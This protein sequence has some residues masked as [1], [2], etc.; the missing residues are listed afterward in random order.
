M[1]MTTVR[2]TCGGAMTILA[3]LILLLTITGPTQAERS[4]PPDAVD[5]VVGAPPEA[6]AEQSI[7]IPY[8]KLR[9]VFEREGRGVFI[10]YEQF[11]TLWEA[12]RRATPDPQNDATPADALI[13]TTQN[14][15]EVVGDAV[16]VS[17]MIHIEVFKKGWVRVPLRLRDAAIIRATIA[18]QPARVVFDPAHGH[19]LIY[20]HQED[21]PAD[22]QLRLEY[23]KAVNK[24][25]GRHGVA[26]GPPQA[27]VSRWRITV[28]E[29]D[30]KVE[31]EPMIATTQTA[32]D[33]HTIKP[34]G[35]GD[36]GRT[37]V[38]AFVGAAPLVRIHW[39]PKSEG[40]VG[41]AALAELR[42]RQRVWVEE[43]VA[44]VRADLH[45]QISRAELTSLTLDLPSDYKITDV[46][47]ANARR[48][49]V[50]TNGDGQRLTV[51]LFEPAD[52]SQALT[53]LLERLIGDSPRQ[54]LVTPVIKAHGVARQRGV[55]AVHSGAGLVCEVASSRGVLQVGVDELTADWRAGGW[56]F[57]YRYAALP[58]SL[59][60]SVEK[61]EPVVRARV[62]SEA[63]IQPRS[64]RL[65]SNVVFDV[66]RTG[67]FQFEL[68]VPSGFD[69]ESVR[70]VALAGSAAATVETHH[71]DEA[72][73]RLT[74]NLSR[75]AMGETGLVVDLSRPLDE[76]NLLAPTGE[77]AQISLPAARAPASFVESQTGR[78]VIRVPESLRVMPQDAS[79]YR[80]VPV[81]EALEHLMPQQAGIVTGD[82]VLAFAYEPTAGALP[83][84]V[85]RRQPHAVVRQ[86]LVAGIKPGAVEYRARFSYDIRYS[87]L[88]TLRIDVPAEVAPRIRNLSTEI[89]VQP[90]DPQPEDLAADTVAW[91]FVGRDQFLGNVVIQLAWEDRLD[92][93][94]TGK[95]VLVRVPKLSPSGTQ[96]AWGQVVLTRAEGI[97]VQP[98]EGVLKLW[99]IDPRHDLMPDAGVSD[100]ARA[101]EFHDAG[102]SLELAATHYELERIKRTSIERA[103]VRMV[104]TRSD[105]IAVQAL[106]RMRSARQR[107]RLRLPDE[108]RFDTHPLRINGATTPLERGDQNE[109]M[110]PLVGRSAETPFILEVRYTVPD[111]TSLLDLPQFVD[112]P[113]AQN[114]YLS[115]Y[116]P[117]KRALIGTAGPWTGHSGGWLGR[118]DGEASARNKPDESLIRWVIENVPVSSDPV[119][120]FQTDGRRYLFSTLSPQ[121]P[122]DG[123]LRLVTINR[124]VLRMATLIL[125]PGCGLVLLLTGALSR[126]VAVGVAAVG[127]LLSGV[128]APR[129]AAEISSVTALVAALVVLIIWAVH[130]RGWVRPRLLA[131]RRAWLANAVAAASVGTDPPTS[132]GTS[133]DVAAGGADS[134]KES[135]GASHD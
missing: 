85:D 44:R 70:G 120:G 114:V 1:P 123:S 27:P 47:D 132:P 28:P 53:I 83:L 76:P 93:T 103:V 106:Y 110:V 112:D 129:F 128:F 101:F 57:A 116:L 95:P 91:G 96:R 80:A 61:I 65:V 72:S 16:R 79:G 99:P 13:L 33:K 25:P 75:R 5:S 23:A 35:T 40:A 30:A 125:I 86:L 45:Y 68:V 90:L 107:L 89:R 39:T 127:L 56:D 97:D 82:P 22:I 94:E 4:L 109:F 104:L 62:L 14:E 81:R 3:A 36:D 42:L 11:R 20:Q 15:A 118:L 31:L 64:L 131:E 87:P 6:L 52:E 63:H 9:E 108:A 71:L 84:R 119:V 18:D 49:S 55:I 54:E 113:A 133:K 48:W 34:A 26:F 32:S 78:V 126:C 105:Q 92:D 111:A 58:Y 130:Y 41:M 121:P 19:E 134:P 115:V 66:Q 59:V 73:R 10:P 69:V 102:W 21:G 88:E 2:S 17:S 38:L 8:K 12:A 122:P 100:A 29:P 74:V 60:V 24:S 50:E 98:T 77:S 37:T 46:I 135:G 7:Y 117:R 43:G 124:T 51:D 67:V